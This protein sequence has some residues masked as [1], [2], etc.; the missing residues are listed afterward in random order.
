MWHDV[1][2]SSKVKGWV[3]SSQ[4]MPECNFPS[5]WN[6]CVSQSYCNSAIKVYLRHSGSEVGL[7]ETRSVTLQFT[8]VCSSGGAHSKYK[9]TKPH[10]SY[11]L[12]C[13]A[14]KTSDSFKYIY[15]VWAQILTCVSQGKLQY[16]CFHMVVK[17][18]CLWWAE[19][20]G[21]P[22]AIACSASWGVFILP[23]PHLP[24]ATQHFCDCFCFL[25]PADT[26]YQLGFNVR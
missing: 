7:N 16:D 15:R 6:E 22:H 25:L 19:R 8:D 20:C 23:N 13:D 1:A 3:A 9:V 10:V 21:F 5:Y 11:G 12:S 26:V 2:F 17:Q 24:R 4:G 14:I 18:A